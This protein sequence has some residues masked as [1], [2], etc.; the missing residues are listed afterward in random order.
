MWMPQ[1]SPNGDK[2]VFNHAKMGADGKTDRRELAMMDFDDATNTFSNLKVIVSNEG[3]APSARLRAAAHAQRSGGAGGQRQLQPRPTTSDV[4]AIPRGTVHGSVLPGLAVLHAGRRGR[5]LRADQRARLHESRSR[6]A[7]RLPRA[8]SG[9]STSR[10]RSK[11]PARRRQQGAGRRRR[12]R[13]LL[14]D[15]AAGPG[16]RLLLAVLD[17]DASVGTS[18]LRKSAGVIRPD[19]GVL[20]GIRW[21][22]RLRWRRRARGQRQQEAHLGLG[23]QAARRSPR[24]GRRTSSDTSSPGF[25]LEGQT[26]SGNVRAFA[27]L[28]PCQARRTDCTSGLDCC[29]GFCNIPNGA[30]TRA[31]AYPTRRA[32]TSTRSAKKTLTAARPRRGSRSACASAASAA[33]RFS[34]PLSAW[35]EQ[36]RPFASAR[37]RFAFAVS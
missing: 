23:H 29:T 17:L 28:N 36:R 35:Q 21:H 9:T 1:F 6:V 16:R 8:S 18:R 25:Y 24:P 32:A 33:S 7:T 20:A 26:D 12:A 31:R 30:Q 14:P 11:R 4:G 37:G 10:P 22:S 15:R 13:Q 34:E 27:T 5:R 3:P 19:G 2:V